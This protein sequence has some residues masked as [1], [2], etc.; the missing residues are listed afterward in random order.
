MIE[1]RFFT[2]QSP[3]IDILSAQSQSQHHPQQQEKQIPNIGIKVFL[4][5]YEPNILLD[6]DTTTDAGAGECA[7]DE[8]TTEVAYRVQSDNW[9]KHREKI[10]VCEGRVGG[11]GR[12]GRRVGIEVQWWREEDGYEEEENGRDSDEDCEDEEEDDEK[13]G[14][15]EKEEEILNGAVGEKR[16]AKWLC[17]RLL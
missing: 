8:K 6:A 2:I 10:G 16:R 7:K 5:I 13:D 15:A 11:A 17:R 3:S 1:T 12:R 9:E 4:H 14:N